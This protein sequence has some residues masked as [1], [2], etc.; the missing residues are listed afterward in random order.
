M[1]CCYLMWC[2]VSGIYHVKVNNA[3]LETA[4]IRHTADVRLAGAPMFTHARC[5][6]G[7]ET[8]A[9]SKSIV[10]IGAR[11][12]GRCDGRQ[13]HLDFQSVRVAQNDKPATP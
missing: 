5:D 7:V 11:F 4:G 1:H 13:P 9:G 10:R 6:G 12:K 8:P 2:Q 3:E